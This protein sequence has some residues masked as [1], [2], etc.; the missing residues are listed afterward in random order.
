MGNPFVFKEINEHF[1]GKEWKP[2]AQDKINC[3]FE[4]YDSCE[5]LEMIK[6]SDLKSKAVQLTKGIEFTKQ[7]RV[8]LINS[9]SIEEIKSALNEFEKI[10]A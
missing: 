10:L 5:K 7:T 1:E 3:F 9:K 2:S 8:K 4:Y 6:L